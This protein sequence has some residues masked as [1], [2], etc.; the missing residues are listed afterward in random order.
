MRTETGLTL[1]FLSF[2]EIGYGLIRILPHEFTNGAVDAV[3]SQHDITFFNGPIRH[4]NLYP[5]IGFGNTHD[6]H[7]C[8]DVGLVW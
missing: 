2:Y 1:L 4:D 6:T 8:L 5:S 7:S 3:T